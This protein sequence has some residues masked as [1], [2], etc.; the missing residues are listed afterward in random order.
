MKTR[1]GSLK[2]V[3]R[4]ADRTRDPTREKHEAADTIYLCLRRLSAPPIP[5]RPEPSRSKVAGSGTGVASALP[6]I[7]TPV[8]SMK[9]GG[10]SI[11]MGG[12]S[13]GG[14]EKVHSIMG[15]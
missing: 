3:K 13:P 6:L 2:F 12:G 11:T 5:A 14:T 10:R 4:S 8:P 7:G 15:T 9:P 1:L